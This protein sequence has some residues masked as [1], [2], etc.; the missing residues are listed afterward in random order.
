MT[1]IHGTVS[2]NLAKIMI[3]GLSKMTRTHIHMI[4]T[5]PEKGEVMSGYRR[6]C[7][8]LIWIDVPKA[9]QKGLSFI[10]PRMM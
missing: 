10:V 5:P 7:N 2:T 8:R 1:A 9:M 4:D 3:D 6:S